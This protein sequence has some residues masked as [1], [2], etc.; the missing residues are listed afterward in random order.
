MREVDECSVPTVT[1]V[2]VHKINQMKS[3]KLIKTENK[4]KQNKKN[5]LNS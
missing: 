4:T 5:V 3:K 2:L 1:M